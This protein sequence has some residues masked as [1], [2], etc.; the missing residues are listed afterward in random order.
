MT[1]FRQGDVV[2]L[3]FPFT[4]LSTFKQ[5]PGVIVSSDEFNGAHPDVIVLAI[6][7]HLPEKLAAGDF[8]LETSELEAAGLPKRSLVKLGKVVTLDQRL[9]RKKLGSLPKPTLGKPVAEFRR[10]F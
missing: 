7:S 4:D 1:G 6:T 9:I 5:R 3:P 10:T 2:L 8:L